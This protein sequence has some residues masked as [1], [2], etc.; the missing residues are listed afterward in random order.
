MEDYFILPAHEKLTHLTSKVLLTL[1]FNKAQNYSA[2]HK[3]HKWLPPRLMLL[4]APLLVTDS[5]LKIDGIFSPQ[6]SRGHVTGACR[7]FCRLR[8]TFL[9]EEVLPEVSHL[10]QD[11]LAIFIVQIQVKGLKHVSNYIN[12]SNICFLTFKR[13]FKPNVLMF[14]HKLQYL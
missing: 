8:F 6:T 5:D 7:K 9:R 12:K 14:N 13:L 11:F 2:L 4:P 3:C 10:L 1:N